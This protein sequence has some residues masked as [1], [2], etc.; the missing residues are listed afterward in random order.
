MLLGCG[1]GDDLGSAPDVR[2]LV[3]PD[4]KRVLKRSNYRASVKSDA[5]FGVIIEEHFTVCDEHS[6]HGRL[7]PLDVSKEC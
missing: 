7:V 3:L 2:G 1:G 5:M 6:P 4:A